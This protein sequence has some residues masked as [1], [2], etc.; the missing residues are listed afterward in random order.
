MAAKEISPF[1]MQGETR[2]C[3]CAEG[4]GRL[5]AQ[6]ADGASCSAGGDHTDH[7]GSRSLFLE[8]MVH[9]A[10]SC[11]CGNSIGSRFLRSSV[12][13]QAA[14]SSG[15]ADRLQLD[16]FLFTPCLLEVVASQCTSGSASSASHLVAHHRAL[17]IAS[18]MEY[19][20]TKK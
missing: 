15:R 11:Y 9:R 10:T 17:F 20:L 8:H 6:S 14:I 1:S 5:K 16:P 12:F 18:K 13:Q 2:V 7:V 19:K 4:V 3:S